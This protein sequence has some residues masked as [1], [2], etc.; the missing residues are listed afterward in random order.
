VTDQDWQRLADLLANWWPGEWTAARDEAY[1]VA[2]DR[3]TPLQVLNALEARLRAGETFRPS[4]AQL[5]AAI[6]GQDMPPAPSWPAVC[7]ALA[8]HPALRQLPR[9]EYSDEENARLARAVAQAALEIHPAVAGMLA[10]VGVEVLRNAPLDQRFPPP[11][12]ERGIQERMWLARLRDG[13][14]VRIDRWNAGDHYELEMAHIADRL[15]PEP[16]HED[17][18]GVVAAL[19]PAEQLPAG[20]GEMSTTS[21]GSGS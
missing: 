17:M 6:I 18:A 7:E 9:R 4:A 13:F 1:R 14:Q 5:V 10:D 15:L 8:T 12:G 2:L 11:D 19:R 20:T 21:G 3:Y 16:V